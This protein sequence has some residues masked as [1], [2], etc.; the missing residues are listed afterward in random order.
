MQE[1]HDSEKS[2]G[3]LEMTTTI[4]KEPGITQIQSKRSRKGVDAFQAFELLNQ[5]GPITA[6]CLATQIGSSEI[7]ARQWLDAQVANSRL[8]HQPRTGFYRLSAGWFSSH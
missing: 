5:G 2:K 3:G 8:V 7:P 4:S 1:T 6:A